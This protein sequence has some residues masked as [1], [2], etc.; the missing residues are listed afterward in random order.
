MA[1]HIKISDALDVLKAGQ[2]A[3]DSAQ[4]PFMILVLVAEDAPRELVL[5]VKDALQ[6]DCIGGEV[7]VIA[8]DS[9]ASFVSIPDAAIILCGDDVSLSRAAAQY[10]A[11]LSVSVACVAE[12]SLELPKVEGDSASRVKGISSA[13]PERAVKNLAHW[14]V[15]A[16]DKH[17]AIATNFEFCRDDEV[18]RLTTECAAQCAAVGALGFVPGA[19]LPVMCANQSKLALQMATI[20]GLD[21][22]LSRV[23]DV[24]GVV[25][26]GF[27]WRAL[28]RQ[29]VTFVP[30]IGWVLKAGIG[31]AGTIAT[32]SALRAKLDPNTETH[33]LMEEAASG[34]SS[35]KNLL[36]KKKDKKK[37]KTTTIDL[38]LSPSGEG[39]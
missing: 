39:A 21:L 36:S 2:S 1:K 34:I 32:A 7:D 16:T 18:K 4:S 35:L 33:K 14:L 11:D 10:F 6:A 29:L 12:T 27:V 17:I 23:G 15:Y 22:N 38:K 37:A 9:Y 31:Y 19:D 26:A 8:L 25:G 13:S 24:A 20:Y 5:A 30:G 28:A 3:Q